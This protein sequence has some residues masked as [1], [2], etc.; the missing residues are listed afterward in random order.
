MPADLPAERKFAEFMKRFR[1][2]AEA[3]DVHAALN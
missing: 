2:N 1:L 3:K